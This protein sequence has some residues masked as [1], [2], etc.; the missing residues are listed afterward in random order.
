M[1]AMILAAG[2]GE[3]MRP[4]TELRAKPALPVLNRPLLHRTIEQIASH[5]IRELVINTHHLPQTLHSAVGSGRRFGVRISWSD[6][7]VILGTGGGLRKAR[8]LLGSGPVLVVNGDVVFDFDLPGLIDRHRRKGALVTLGLR[9]NRDASSYLPIVTDRSGRVLWLPGLEPNEALRNGSHS[10]RM[11][12]GVQI[13][14]ARVIERLSEGFADSIRD[15]AAPLVAEG[16]AVMGTTLRGAWYDLGRPKL[17]LLAQ[18][19]LL[20]KEAGS[21]SLIHPRARIGGG[22]RIRRSVIGERARIGD[23]ASIDGSVVWD[24]AVVG[25]Q[26]TVRTCILAEGAKVEDGAQI[27]ERIAMAGGEVDL[28]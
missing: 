21:G 4:L 9:P 11:F 8:G 5:G 17:Y 3:R 7:D 1:K 14:E 20:R 28:H 25:R 16:A 10:R 2:L 18:L 12:T 27:R 26:A 13:I 22:C 19:A 24:G 23:G 6:E 15:L